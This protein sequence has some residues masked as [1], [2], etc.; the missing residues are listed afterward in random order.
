MAEFDKERFAELLEA[1]KGDRSIRKYAQDSGVSAAHISRLLRKIN[2]VAPEP[3]TIKK[4]AASAYNG[5]TYDDFMKAAGYIDVSGESKDIPPLP[6]EY[7]EKYKFSRRDINQYEEVMKH[8]S[9]F[10]MN[11]QISDEDKERLMYSLMEVFVRS[12]EINRKKYG[13]K[14]NNET[15]KQ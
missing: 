2:D 8:T 5:I 10:F 15:D 1:A 7:I 14:K 11:D 3:D 9:A 13:E 4:F 12:K 6:S